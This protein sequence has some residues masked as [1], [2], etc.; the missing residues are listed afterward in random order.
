[1]PVNLK[2]T[3]VERVERLMKRHPEYGYKDVSDFLEDAVA[4]SLRRIRRILYIYLLVFV[5]IS[6]ILAYLILA[7]LI[8][9]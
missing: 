8:L 1:M 5:S 6:L 9:R 3:L 7:Y 4:S 2:K